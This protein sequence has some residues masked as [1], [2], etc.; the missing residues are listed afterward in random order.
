MKAY[1]ISILIFLGFVYSCKKDIERQIPNDKITLEKINYYKY[2]VSPGD[3][4]FQF[5]LTYYAENGKPHRWMLLDP[6]GRVMTD[7][8]YE[9]DSAWQHTGARYREEGAADFSKEKVRYKNDST[10]I[11][12]WV[13]SLGKVYYT[14]IDNL[15]A[16]NKTYRAA[17]IGDKLHGYD[18]TFYTK[19]GFEKRIFFTNTKGKVFNDRSFIYDSIN[20]F[21]D[22]IERKKIMQDTLR[23]LHKREVYYGK[24][25]VSN[26]DKFYEGIVSTGEL[27][28]NV[29]NFSA[30]ES[31]LFLTRTSG[32]TNQS[33][34]IAYKK[35]GLFKETIPIEEL[36]S[37]YNGAISPKGNKI[38][39]S[40]REGNQTSIWLI[41]KENGAWS[42]RINL[43]RESNIEGGYFYWLND[44]EIYFYNEINNGDILLGEI[45]KGKLKI[46]DSLR[47]L[48]TTSGT[49]FSPFVDKSKRY[50]IFTRY[51]EGNESDQ[52]FFVSYNQNDFNNPDWSK[53]QKITKLPYGWSAN[54]VNGGT[55]FIYSNGEDI[56]SLPVEELELKI[57]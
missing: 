40:I 29:I 56:M 50:I 16:N 21:G 34:Y 18:S 35:N 6:D 19:E 47:S 49:E 15:N 25:Y 52:G 23:E 51:V 46:K 1:F 27:S 38:I 32:W 43:T 44:H 22:W 37:V 41:S 10:M 36:D 54:I 7:Y 45:D 13:D 39:Y 24:D 31:I 3:S 9:Y 5:R 14:M 55:Q 2:P 4:P 11:T 28:E 42:N 8:I 20:P 53:P 30:D 48:N 12:E 17:F 33:A 26:N 57:N